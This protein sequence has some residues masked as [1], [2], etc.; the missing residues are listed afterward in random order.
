MPTVVPTPTTT[1]L[2][3]ALSASDILL[4]HDA[5]GS[6][7]KAQYANIGTGAATETTT[8]AAKAAAA[9]DNIAGDGTSTYVG[10]SNITLKQALAGVMRDVATRLR[11]DVLLQQYGAIWTQ[12]DNH[13]RA[14]LPSG[15]N[16]TSSAGNRALDLWMM[17]LN[18]TSA[19]APATPTA[20]PVA[21][22]T[23]GGTIPTVSSGNAPR[24]KV[25]YQS[26]NGD[27]LVSQPSAASAQVALSG[28]NNAYSVA[29]AGNAPVT[30][31]LLYFRQLAGAAAGDPYY[32]DQRVAI[33]SGVAHPTTVMKQSDQQLLRFS[34]PSWMSCMAMPE[35]AFLYALSFAAMQSQSGSQQGLLAFQTSSFLSP[36]NVALNPVYIDSALTRGY[37]GENNAPSSG[38]FGSWLTAAYTEG[39]LATANDATNIIQGFA[40]AAG[41][42]QAR[43]VTVLNAGAALTNVGYSYYDAA[44]PPSGAVQTT[45]IPAPGTL[46]AAVGSTLDLGI[47]ASRLVTRI[48]GVTT[49]GA[50]TGNYI[51]E[52]KPL[53]TI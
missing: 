12:L 23:T 22:A 28:A 44:N 48:S 16:F 1:I 42:V 6:L 32:Y 4:V 45:T 41:G 53:R 29:L 34:P 13:V 18:A 19:S 37:L 36:S 52:A 27:W 9:R 31:Y 25:C 11:Y 21:T 39:T 2:Q 20:T 8:L 24:I 40:G 10:V 46:S 5:L 38:Q 26:S 33:T 43:T 7:L 35:S 51:M 30:G 15:W 17:Y 3:G 49:G 47:T 50:T 14:N